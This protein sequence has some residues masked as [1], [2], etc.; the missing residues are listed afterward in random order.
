MQL[1]QESIRR[2]IR[3]KGLKY[4]KKQKPPRM[5]KEGKRL[6]MLSKIKTLETQPSKK[7]QDLAPVKPHAMIDIEN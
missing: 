5:P 7:Y 6:K 3:P 1:L 4:V 2:K